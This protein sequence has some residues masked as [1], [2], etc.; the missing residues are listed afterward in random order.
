[1][2]PRPTY[3]WSSVSLAAVLLAGAAPPASPFSPT[4]ATGL[5]PALLAVSVNG[6]PQG[7][8]V[9][10]LKGPDGSLYATEEAISAW[11]LKRGDA[12][13]ISHEGQTYYA[14]S[15]IQGL[16]L[17]LVEAT[18][19]LMVTAPPGM[20][21]PTRIAYDPV[22]VGPMTP[23]GTGGFLNYD[24]LGQLADGETSLSGSVE[25]GAFT[26]YGV[27]ISSFLGRW[28]AGERELIRLDTSWTI[29]D[30]AHMRSL[31]I[32]DTISRGGVGGGPLR[33]GG[34]QFARNFAVQPGYVT[35][36]MPSVQGSAA[37]PSVV[38]VYVNNALRD[39]REV[40]PGPF[41]IT[42]VPVVTGGGDVQ[43][44]VRDLLGRE[45]VV[46]QSYYAAPQL[47]RR[48]L[49][50][51]SY[52][53]GFLRRNFAR[54]SMDYGPLFVSTT[55]RYGLTDTLTGEVHV[56]ATEEVQAGGLAASVLLPGIGL[57]DASVAASSSDRG[58]GALAAIGFER[59]TPSLS[60]GMLAEFT[61]D[62]YVAVGWLP[63]REAPAMI[64][65][66][67]AGLPFRFGSLGL[68][69]LRR[70]GR[71]DADIELLSANASLRVG[72]FGTLHLA[73]RTSLRGRRDTAVELL[74]IVPLGRRTS[75]S[76]GVEL[77]GGEAS[78]KADLQRNLPAGEG[79]GYRAAMALGA[80][81]RLDGRLSLQTG[82]GAYDAELT[83][84]EGNKGIRVG[85]TGGIGVI[86][87]HVFASRRLS[88]SF[89]MVD[90]GDYS[91][92]RVYADNQLVGTSDDDGRVV[93][94]RLRPYD[95]NVIRIEVADL[96]LDAEVVDAERSVRPY[97]RSGVAVDFGAT[98]SRA[99]LL[100][101][102]LE[103]GEPLPAGSAVRLEGGSED[104]VSAPGG[105]VYLTG[106][107][108]DNLARATWSAGSCQVR[109]R[110]ED[111]DDPQPRLGDHRCVSERQ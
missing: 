111:S 16:S 105:E 74:L 17:D 65:Q 107:A 40:P 88:Q 13:A 12:P 45:T 49:H 64:L 26:P 67:F 10:L 93:I 91:G 4:Q 62:D 94:A 83:W 18:Q 50:D 60:F 8:P 25:L 2:R 21:E 90:V 37:V 34:F 58:E 96:P 39:S 9:V 87:G 52:E 72:P 27:G 14:L 97:D 99:A 1:M 11:R 48:G 79:F 85:A 100:R 102:L 38:D 36:P 75:A 89:A 82:F 30:P 56:E 28:S 20:L 31:R 55:Q 95:R 108:A 66:G 104:F 81:D 53:I 98:R 59:R 84:V 24:L 76:G 78:L 73:G 6:A 35:L 7:E 71:S 80:I 19:T 86:D 29:D 44:I 15:A 41:E 46:S 47:V 109:F 68:S 110:F 77:R 70:D 63:G 32:G 51:Y 23:S 22:D 57:L 33:F 92:V 43:L 106:L 101:I 42:G 69:Y 3:W 5:Q 61:T 103:N 54:E